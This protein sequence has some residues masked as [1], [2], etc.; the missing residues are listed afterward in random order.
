[1]GDEDRLN[2]AIG[3]IERLRAEM[4]LDLAIQEMVQLAELL[5]RALDDARAWREA[6]A[7]TPIPRLVHSAGSK[8]WW[9]KRLASGGIADQAGWHGQGSSTWRG[10]SSHT[11]RQLCHRHVIRIEGGLVVAD[12]ALEAKP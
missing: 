12:T 1:M 11:I 7:T 6:A 8:R 9:W 4:R 3:E 2:D 10:S 5:R